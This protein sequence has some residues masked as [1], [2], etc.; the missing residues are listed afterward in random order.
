MYW[1]ELSYKFLK[2]RN[3]D[4]DVHVDVDVDA[5]VDAD[6]HAHAHVPQQMVVF[7]GTKLVH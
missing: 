2:C 3:A 5:Y 6:A 7:H 4:A 1:V